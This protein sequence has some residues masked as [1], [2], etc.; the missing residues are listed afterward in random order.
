MRKILSTAVLNRMENP[1]H[2]K[3]RFRAF[4]ITILCLSLLAV[5]SLLADQSARYRHGVQYGATQRRALERL[6]LRRLVKRDE[7]VRRSPWQY[8]PTVH[9]MLESNLVFCLV[10]STRSSCRRQVRFH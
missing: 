10:V 7:E 8:P 6:D 4:Y 2:R 3:Y 5:A 1:P 9:R